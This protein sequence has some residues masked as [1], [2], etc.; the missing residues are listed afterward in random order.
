[1]LR[2][3]QQDHHYSS[4]LQRAFD[5]VAAQQSDFD[6][7]RLR[8]LS[9]ETRLQT[10][11]HERNILQH[12]PTDLSFLTSE[13]H[14]VNRSVDALDHGRAEI[15]GALPFTCRFTHAVQGE[16]T[17]YG[18][19]TPPLAMSP[20]VKETIAGHDGLDQ[21]RPAQLP[22]T[23][24]RYQRRESRPENRSD[25]QNPNDPVAQLA[26]QYTALLNDRN[27]TAVLDYM[28]ARRGDELTS[29]LADIQT[30]DPT[31]LQAETSSDERQLL[32]DVFRYPAKNRDTRSADVPSPRL[33]TQGM[34]SSELAL[35]RAADA[36]AI[37]SITANCG[38]LIAQ[39]DKR[40]CS[41]NTPA[42]FDR[43]GGYKIDGGRFSNLPTTHSAQD[44]LA[45]ATEE[46]ERLA[47]AVRRTIHE[48]ERA[49]GSVQPALPA[50]PL[51]LGTLRLS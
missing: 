51:N 9:G 2:F 35:E 5:V 45:A 43:D 42:D 14:A 18:N 7:R 25:R 4:A 6:S 17:R 20:E 16:F 28:S 1:M 50:L 36:P 32:S 21:I 10:T 19:V 34:I 26:P 29:P 46:V 44:T 47:A 39:G 31:R 30:P 15:D 11:G 8:R 13:S 48:L 27:R 22:E 41:T 49:R 37:D 3:I 12:S 24:T 33:L 40:P 23:I 38:A